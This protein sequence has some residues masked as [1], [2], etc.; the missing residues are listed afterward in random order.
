MNNSTKIFLCIVC[1]VLLSGVG[2]KVFTHKTKVASTPVLNVY[3]D[4]TAPTSSGGNVPAQIDASNPKEAKPGTLWGAFAKYVDAARRHDL[5][6]LSAVAYQISDTCKDSKEQKA[7]FDKMDAVVSATSAFSESEFVRS[8]E[9]SK[10]GI[11]AT[12]LKKISS[13]KDFG[14]VRS[15]ILFI[16]D[17]E[18]NPKL[19]A[20]KPDETWKVK[21][22]PASTTAELDARLEAMVKDSDNDGVPDEVEKCI[23][24]DNFIAFSCT[25][26][27]PNK[28][29][30]DGD[31]YFDSIG[32]FVKKP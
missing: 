30:S 8:I 32:Q 6:A 14:Y 4:T 7:C 20:I 16:K 26:T 27:N 21:R 2:V 3:T 10:Q 11:L 9:D 17:G 13:D 1:A 24:A 25:E 12:N 31:G 18:G 23:F 29:D 15:I 28:K 19:V 22:N 5:T